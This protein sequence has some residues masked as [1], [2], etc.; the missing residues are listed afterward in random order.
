[1]CLT[2]LVLLLINVLVD[3]EDFGVDLSTFA[4]A[5]LLATLP[6]SDAPDKF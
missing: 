5:I 3:L 6:T 1:L 2:L 4:R